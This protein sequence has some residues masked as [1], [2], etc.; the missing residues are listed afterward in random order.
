[1]TYNEAL[2][3]VLDHDADAIDKATHDFFGQT[4][5]FDEQGRLYVE[6]DQPVARERQ[7]AF[8]EWARANWN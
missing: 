2:Q 3:L 8:A 4:C 1:M 6:A 5:G 7:I